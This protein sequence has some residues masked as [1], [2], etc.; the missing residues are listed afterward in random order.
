L[1]GPDT[2]EVVMGPLSVSVLALSSLLKGLGPIGGHDGVKVYQRKDAEVIELAAVGEFDAPPDQVQ[3]TLLDYGAHARVNR[4]LAESRVL[5]RRPGELLV[6][7]RLKLPVIKDRD[8]T[9]RVAWTEDAT[10]GISFHIDPSRGP[11]PTTKAVRMSLLDGKWEL[12]AIRGGHATRAV[13][14]FRIGFAGAVPRW[15][16]RGGAAKDLPGVFIGI[17]QLLAE[18][19]TSADVSSSRR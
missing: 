7:Q 6:Y 11:A 18:G 2:H 13:Y 15:M 17:R 4:H 8:F 12:T 16:V 19:R 14:W 9:L 1:L 5:S 10:R 3:A